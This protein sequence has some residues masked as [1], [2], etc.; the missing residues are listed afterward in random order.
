MTDF[1]KTEDTACEGAEDYVIPV[2]RDKVCP[3]QCGVKKWCTAFT[4]AAWEGHPGSKVCRMYS[5]CEPKDG[6]T[7]TD[8]YRLKQRLV[9]SCI[10]IW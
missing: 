7:G 5:K 9:V 2:S 10:V 1:E 4:L 6:V 3:A 8:L